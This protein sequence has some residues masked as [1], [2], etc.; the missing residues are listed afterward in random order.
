MRPR[1]HRGVVRSYFDSYEFNRLN[2]MIGKDIHGAKE[3]FERYLEK[4]H[5]DLSAYLKYA[6]VLITTGDFKK[7]H[8]MIEL[9]EYKLARTSFYISDDTRRK[10]VNKM[11]IHT[12][13]RL[14]SN[15]KR[16]WAA[17]KLIYDHQDIFEDDRLKKATIF[18]L[19]KIVNNHIRE[20]KDVSYI[21]RQ[22]YSYSEEEMIEHIKKHEADYNMGDREISTSYFLPEIEIEK[23]IEEVKKNLKPENALYTGYFDN[24]Y[25]F[26]LDSCGRCDN[27]L[28][29]YLEV[30]AFNG[31]PNIITMYPV[32]H[33]NNR[34]IVDLNYMREELEENKPKVKTLSQI[35]KFR[36]RYSKNN[37]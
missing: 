23:L 21:Y 19:R 34:N 25:C 16:V 6:E 8:E 35:D 7:A 13:G 1:T 32:S 33:T 20:K 22:I 12:K 10:A 11:I 24:T 14:Y 36:M 2:E 31:S 27:K 5:N 9:V 15:E 30:V 37:D 4:Y 17:L 26:R 29:D 3:G 18:Y 28:V